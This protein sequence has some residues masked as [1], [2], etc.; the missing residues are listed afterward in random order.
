MKVII[1]GAGKV[2]LSIAQYLEKHDNDVIVIDNS[3]KLIKK[4]TETLDVRALLGFASDPDVL[5]KAGASEADMIVAVTKVDEVNLVACEVADAVFQIPQKMA[6][7]R[8]QSYLN[9]KWSRIFE[10][11]YLKV[12][13]V[14]TPEIEISQK[15][16]KSLKIP[17]VF[18]LFPMLDGEFYVVGMKCIAK[19]PIVNTPIAYVNSLFPDV[20]FKVFAI[21]RNRDLMMPG[22][23]EKI[24]KGDDVYFA[25]HK[26]DIEKAAKA[27]Y[28]PHQ[29]SRRILILGGGNI[30]FNLAKEIHENIP[31]IKIKIIEKNRERAQF[32]STELPNAVI[33]KGDALDSALLKEAGVQDVETVIA[34]TEDDKVNALSS[35][36]AKQKGAERAVVLI[37]KPGSSNLVSSLGVDSV[38]HPRSITVS[39]V[40]RNI[41]RNNFC[42]YYMIKEG[43]GELIDAEISKNARLRG[44]KISDINKEQQIR[45]IAVMRDN[46]I[47]FVKD[48]FVLDSGDKLILVAHRLAV[49][50]LEMIFVSRSDYF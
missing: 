36:L 13:N 44:S 2:G 35:L 49:K 25:C 47:N 45:V 10:D 26:A 31:T 9:P 12:D 21:Y 1:C 37:N 38:V 20:K 18:S 33:Y 7:V 39:S 50:D 27:F 8:N 40:L 29:S 28:E 41:K 43:E 15:I 11:Q 32:L 23:R 17:G 24:I 16:A 14:I 5:Y 46:E 22:M 34:V 6:R 48:D 19:S 30:G 42:S 3:P 4:I